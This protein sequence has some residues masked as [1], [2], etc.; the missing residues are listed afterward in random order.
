MTRNSTTPAQIHP[1]EKPAPTVTVPSIPFTAKGTP[2]GYL[3]R[4][5]IARPVL[6]FAFSLVLW[7]R[8]DFMLWIV[9]IA[10]LIVGIVV[11]VSLFNYRRLAVDE[12]GIEYRGYFGKKTRYNF[13][14]IESAK[15][16]LQFFDFSFGLAPRLSIA[17]KGAETQGISLNALYWDIEDLQRIALLLEEKGV[18]TEYY[19]DP[20]AYGDIAALFPSYATYVERHIVRVAVITSIVTIVG[21]VAIAAFMTFVL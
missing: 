14:D 11:G 10:L 13:S 4:L 15:V 6:A 8:F 19:G 9:T 2:K 1:I 12:A 17:K 16:F 3:K 5:G 20:V 21:I 18:T 7:W